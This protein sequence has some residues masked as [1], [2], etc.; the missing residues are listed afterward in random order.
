MSDIHV[1]KVGG[2]GTT[3]PYLSHFQDTGGATFSGIQRLRYGL[4]RQNIAVLGD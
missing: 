1:N 2:Q 4:P 3:W